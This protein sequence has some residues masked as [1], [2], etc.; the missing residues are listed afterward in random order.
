MTRSR[1]MHI[2]LIIEMTACNVP[3][4]GRA[5][6]GAPRLAPTR[7]ESVKLLVRAP[8]GRG[9]RPLAWVSVCL[10][11]TP[12]E[13]AKELRAQAA[14]YGAS[15]VANVSLDVGL[16][17]MGCQPAVLQT[18]SPPVALSGVAGILE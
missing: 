10:A 5:V 7:V 3:Y 18:D 13:A 16:A 8:A 12:D 6:D 2:A 9:F 4:N 15:V 17:G 11:G 1:Y 14:T